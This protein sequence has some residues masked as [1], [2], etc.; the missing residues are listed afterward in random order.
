MIIIFTTVA[1]HTYTYTY[2]IFLAIFIYNL[3]V[4]SRR[5]EAHEESNDKG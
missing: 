1:A 5:K 3:Q 4:K 2:Y